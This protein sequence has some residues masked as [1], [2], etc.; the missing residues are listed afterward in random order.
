MARRLLCKQVEVGSNPI[1]STQMKIQR[2][3]NLCNKEYEAESR[4][5]KRGQG[6]YCS[7]QC[8]GAA[9]KPRIH[10]SILVECGLC[11]KQFSR[12]VSKTK[13]KSGINFCSRKCKDKAQSFSGG[14]VAI[15]P[16]HYGSNPDGVDY[17]SLAFQYFVLQCKECGWNEIPEVLEVNHID[18]DR[19]NNNLSNLEILC[20]TCHAKFHYLTKTGKWRDRNVNT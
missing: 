9:P 11:N 2:L 15:Q 3:C 13:S 10:N 17:R 20:P 1:C 12:Q 7:R 5:L 4:Y 19:K 16:D 18:C 6:V 14:I 8:A